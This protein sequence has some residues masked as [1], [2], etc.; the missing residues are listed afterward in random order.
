MIRPASI[1]VFCHDNA[2]KIP[3]SQRIPRHGIGQC[4]CGI[5]PFSS[6]TT[7]PR[8]GKI[9]P[10]TLLE[11]KGTFL[12]TFGQTFHLFATNHHRR[13]LWHSLTARYLHLF[14]F[15]CKFLHVVF[16]PSTSY[17]HARPIEIGRTIIINQHTRV[18][19]RNTLDRLCLKGKR[20]F[21]PV[22]GSHTN[23]KAATTLRRIG[24]VEVVFPVL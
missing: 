2:L 9:V 8:E 18:Y 4:L 7:H 22:G 11:R 19:A 23:G 1:V 13:H 5:L 14:Q 6:L 15:A 3:W 17:S 20:P 12:E 16:Q 10:T 24:K 21:G